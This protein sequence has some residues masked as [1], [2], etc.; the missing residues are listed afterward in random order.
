MPGLPSNWSGH[1]RTGDRSSRGDQV[2]L[3]FDGITFRY[4]T[5]FRAH[6]APPVFSDFSWTLPAGRTVLLGP[7][8]AGKTTLLSLAATVLR[9]QTGEVRLGNLSC[10]TNAKAVRGSIGLMP[11]QFRAIPGF[12]ARE[13]VAYAAWLRGTG[14]SAA[15]QD[16]LEALERVGLRTEAD[17]LVTSLSGGQQRRIGLAQSIVRPA[18]VLLLDEPTAGLDPAQRSRFRDLL[19]ELPSDAAVL[20]STHQVDDLSDLFGTV[21]VLDHGQIRY[22]GTP[23]EFLRLAPRGSLRPA[24]AAYMALIGSEA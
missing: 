6:P 11:Q 19:T 1:I 3:A 5:R 7:N 15:R 22:Q 8:G 17:A 14:G 23:A 16:A 18:S 9:P 4:R 13:Q 20:V 2:T 10:V 24:E 12:T 21:V